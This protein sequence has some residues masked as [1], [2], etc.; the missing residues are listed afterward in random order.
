MDDRTKRYMMAM[1]RFRRDALRRLQIQPSDCRRQR[2]RALES[3]R[4]V[5]ESEMEGV[6]CRRDYASLWLDVR[7]G[8]E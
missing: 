2:I 6:G 1:R 8:K 4:R 5:E 3:G 7:T